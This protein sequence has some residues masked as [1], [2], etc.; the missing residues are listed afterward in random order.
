MERGSDLRLGLHF[1]PYEGQ[2]TNNEEAANSGYSWLVRST[3]VS[4]SSG[5]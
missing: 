1:G 2:I 3:P 4:L 5:L